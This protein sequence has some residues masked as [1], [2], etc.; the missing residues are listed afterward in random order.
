MHSLNLKQLMSIHSASGELIWIGIRP[1]KHMPMQSV[2][3]VRADSQSGLSG[4]RYNGQSGKRQVTL[5]QWEYL[6]V[7]SSFTGR[8]VAPDLLRRN[9]VIK[10]INLLSLKGCKIQLGEAV[11]QITGLCHP[12]SRMEGILGTGGYNAMRG[13]GGLT[14]GI[15]RSGTL[16]KGDRLIVLP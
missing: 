1:G 3:E 13:H 5:F 16:T 6:A 10:G 8:P 14:A 9:L 15:E 4:D 12:C 7:L 11:L 2:L